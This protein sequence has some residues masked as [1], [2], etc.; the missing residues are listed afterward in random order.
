MTTTRPAGIFSATPAPDPASRLSDREVWDEAERPAGPPAPEDYDYSRRAVAV[1]HH[2]VQVHDHLRAELS[3]IRD[4]LDQVRQG[5]VAPGDARGVLSEMTMRQ[6]NWTLGAYCASYCAMLTG[7]HHMEDVAIFPHLRRSDEGLAPV[8]D[9]LQHEHLVI[10]EVIEGVDRALVTL[11]SNPG[12]YGELTGAVDVLTDALLS[13]LAYEEQ[14]IM[15][16]LARYGFY[17]GQV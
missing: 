2:L 5:S 8:T 13:H 17:P 11:I 7:H 3:Q 1:A 16:P 4:L 6:N 9:R 10:H 15:E 14:Q 12:D